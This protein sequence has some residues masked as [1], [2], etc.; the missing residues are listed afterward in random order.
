[1][2][3]TGILLLAGFAT[4]SAKT[5]SQN[6]TVTINLE[7][8]ALAKVFDAIEAQTDYVLF[9]KKDVVDDAQ[10]VTVKVKNETVKQVL[11][12]VLDTDQVTINMMDNSIVIA[13]LSP[14]QTSQ[15]KNISGKVTDHKGEP[16]PGVSIVIKGTIQGTITDI[17]G[18]YQLD[19]PE[20]ST[21]VFSFIGFKNHEVLVGTQTVINAT[22][23]EENLGL[24]EVVVLG[25]GAVSRKNFTGSVAGVNL[26][27]SPIAVSPK[28]NVLDVLRGSVPGINI[29][30]Q[31]GAGQSPSM[32][33][34]GQKSINGGSDPLIVMDG[35]IFMG[36]MRDI[37]PSTIE[38][39]NVLKD[40]TSI[41][42]YGSRA[43]NGVVMITT[44]KG[45]IGKPV[46]NVESSVA[47]QVWQDRPELLS[48]E[49]YIKKVNLV[50]GLAEDA[51]PTT[52]M[53]LFEK[54]NYAAGK[55]TNWMDLVSRTG[56]MQNYSVSVSGATEGMNYY[57][58][59][60]HT[61]QE[62]VLVGDDYKRYA[63]T[64]RFSFDIN[65]WL[66][67]GMDGNYTF[68]DY[69]GPTNYNIYQAIRLSPYGRVYRPTG[70]LEKYPLTQGIYMT[71]PLWGIDDNTIEDKDTYNTYRFNG[72]YQISCPWVHGLSFKMNYMRSGEYVNRD[73]FTKETYYIKQGDTEDRYSAASI[74]DLLSNA[75]GYVART[76]NN[77]WVWD[78]ILSFQ[79]QLGKHYIDATAVYTRDSYH[80]KKNQFSGS[81]FAALGNTNLG[82]DGLAFAATQ[83]I[84]NI[85]ATL[86]TNIGYLGRVNYSYNDTYHFTASVRH[87]GSSV[88]GADKKWG[89]FP[90]VGMA[91]TASNESFLKDNPQISYL[92]LKASWGKNGNQS[93]DPYKTLSTMTLG[94]TGALGYEFGNTG[95]ISYGQNI[96]TL[97]NTQLAWETTTAFNAG[98]VLGLLNDRLTI[99][100]DG[101][102]SKTSDQIFSR[103][104]PIMTGFESILATMGQVNNHGVEI[105]LKATPVKTKGFEWN[106]L[107][108]FWQNRNILKKLYGVD[109]NND[110]KEDD[111][112]SSGYF[113]DK[114]LG[115]I[116]GYKFIGIVQEDD[117]EYITKNGSKAG[118]PKY[119]DMDDDGT[120]TADDRTI[121]GYNKE[122]FRM[123]FANTISYKNFDLYFMFSGIF[124]GNNYYKA[125]NYY[126][127]G[128]MT[129]VYTDNN[130][131]HG[132]WTAENRSN[133]YPAPNFSN[134]GKFNPLQSRG[135]VRLQDLSLSYTFKQP[136]LEAASIK[137]LKVYLAAK[138][139]LTI[140]NW[141][142]GDPEIS[143]TLGNY[144]IYTYGYPLAASYSVGVNLTF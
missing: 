135:F 76:I 123:S 70:E 61:N 106:T 17:N 18:N 86:H 7:N 19:V 84:D 1:M 21:L 103:T 39:I 105:S 59:S 96:S 28:S 113:I 54:E 29:S 6:A 23:E 132:W 60:S 109:A 91:W 125:S 14:G 143:Q 56:V 120:I 20:G 81:N 98:F 100:A 67:L 37:D 35:V 45:T 68:S 110:G 87:D 108:T 93:L 49:N 25:Y 47:A 124:G 90:S 5:A 121:L 31:Q 99:E 15:S 82:T 71:N 77:A 118:N 140:T 92:K 127:Y 80:Y 73:Y 133:K 48:A 128:T 130:F 11:N 83:K 119:A 41:A 22:M 88:F 144:A 40:A 75:N 43:A 58:A 30:Q 138:N 52:W 85:A 50:Q 107:L 26:N 46:F 114:S 16:L 136:W 111:D 122:N 139:V 74:A 57:L 89:T 36:N 13:P 141:E 66:K 102:L 69:S 142:G 27:E 117:T 104:I 42:A 65:K 126:A 64:S 79:K 55:T 131:N 44:K 53:S 3:L 2:K 97:G 24:D 129:D 63:L 4:L 8:E 115:A 34:R 95:T 38:S 10:K 134:D 12:Q 112:L 78:N 32:L 94:Q 101:Y 72:Y 137:K 51:D 9:Y 116:Y 62:G 33:V